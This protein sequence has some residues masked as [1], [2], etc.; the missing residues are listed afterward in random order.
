MMLL[1]LLIVLNYLRLNNYM[2]KCRHENLVFIGK[3]ETGVINS[4][5]YL[6]NC[7]DCRATIVLPRLEAIRLINITKNYIN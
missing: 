4:F 2:S 1:P 5:L 6:F 3:Q 7:L